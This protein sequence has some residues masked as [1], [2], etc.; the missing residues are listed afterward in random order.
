M[1]RQLAPGAARTGGAAGRAARLESAD[2]RARPGRGAGE[3]AGAGA[4]LRV[5]RG[6]SAAGRPASASNWRCRSSSRFARAASW[7]SAWRSSARRLAGSSWSLARSSAARP[8]FRLGRRRPTRRGGERA[9]AGPAVEVAGQPVEPIDHGAGLGG[10]VRERLPTRLVPRAVA[11]R[12]GIGGVAEPLGLL[13]VG[14]RG[15]LQRVEL[16]LRLGALRL[17]PPAPA[18]ARPARRSSASGGGDQATFGPS[19]GGRL[20]ATRTRYERTSPGSRRNDFRSSIAVPLADR[21]PRPGRGMSTCPS[22]A[23]G[24]PGLGWARSIA[25]CSSAEATARSSR[26]ETPTRKTS[27]GRDSS[28]R[29]VP[30]HGERRRGV[31]DDHHPARGLGEARQAAAV[32]EPDAIG[33]GRVGDQRDGPGLAVR[34]RRDRDRPGGARPLDLDRADRR[35]RSRP[36]A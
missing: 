31:G 15:L 18:S 26:A 22:S 1:A 30:P 11:A 9:E 6:S 29:L 19:G 33:S 7:A 34:P 25:W 27:S 2:A 23:F 36:R 28:H 16:R 21:V 32:A 3:I 5:V 12:G 8:S 13:P 14:R 35:G 4:G 17:A 10:A 24:P 20:S